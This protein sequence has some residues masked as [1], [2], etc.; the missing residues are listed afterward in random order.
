MDTPNPT[1]GAQSALDLTTERDRGLVRRACK[2]WPKRWRGLSDALKDR[3]IEDLKVASDA[4]RAALDDPDTAM[5]A[6]KTL[7]SIA[8]TAAVIEGQNQKDEHLAASL[9][10][11][12]KHL[13]LGLARLIADATDVEIIAEARKLGLINELPP[14]LRL[15]AEKEQQGS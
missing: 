2:E 13:K 9:E 5:D 6:A 10:Q 3:F 12:D 4:A 11:D 1:G 7:S 15:L 8:K 14:R